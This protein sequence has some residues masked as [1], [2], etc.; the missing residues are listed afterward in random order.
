MDN[1]NKVLARR[2]FEELLC[3][4]S[5][6]VGDEILSPECLLHGPGMSLRGRESIK[7]FVAA[8]RLAFPDIRVTD[9]TYIAEAD[10][11]ASTFTMR[12]THFGDFRGLAPTGQSVAVPGV[13]VF[14][15]TGR[16]VDDILVITDTLGLLQQLGV[17]P[18]PGDE[19]PESIT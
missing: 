14:R 4:G 9:Q 7:R 8:L 11:V 13:H 12:G 3:E 18:Y 2:Y 5:L 1:D 15:M 10:R 16:Q 19:I 17:L 6:T